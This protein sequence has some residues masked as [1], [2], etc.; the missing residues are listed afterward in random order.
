MDKRIISFCQSNP[1]FEIPCGNCGY[2]NVF[3]SNEVF[4]SKNDEFIFKCKKCGEDN[5]FIPS[6]FVE[7]YYNSMIQMGFTFD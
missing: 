3:S 4:E 5:I 7:S 1:E 2:E 6:N